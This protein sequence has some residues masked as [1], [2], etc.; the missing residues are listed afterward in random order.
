MERRSEYRFPFSRYPAVRIALLLIAG[1]LLYQ[2]LELSVYTNIILF[3][4]LTGIYLLTEWW[5]NRHISIVWPNIASLLF[6]LI[7]VGFGMF[8]TSIQA[9]SDDSETIQLLQISD[10][11]EVQVSGNVQSMS[12]TSAGKIRWDL[13]VEETKVGDVKTDQAYKSRIL[14][15]ELNQQP[16]LGDE[17]EITGILIPISEKRNPEDFDYKGYLKTQGIS[18]QIK[19]NTLLKVTSNTEVLEWIWW[20]EKALDLVDKNFNETTAPIAKALLV[21]YKQDLSSESKT[22]FA[23]AGLSH[24]MAVSGLHVG[25]IVA[26]FWIII[27][28]FWTKKYGSQIG[29]ALLI[30]LLIYYAG[31]T[32]FSPS[33]MRASVMAVFLSYG[34]LFHRINDSINLTA[35]AAIV[36]LIVD[37]AQ[38]FEIGFQLS[39]A[40]VLIILLMLPVIQNKL[41]YWVRVRWYGKPL[42]VVIVSLV[43]QF[44]L[45]P[46]QVFY[47]GEIS[48][49]SP[50]ANALFVPLLGVVV[51]LSLIALLATSLTSTVGFI[52]NY[53]SLKFLSWMNDFVTS[54]S[55]WDWAWMNASLDSGFIFVF[56]LFLIFAISAWHIPAMR[57]KLSIGIMA[58][59]CVLLSLNVIEKVQPGKLTVTYFDVGQGDAA[60]MK[61]PQGKHILIDVGV[62]SPGY[63][64]GNSVILPHLKSKG[65]N[66]LDA[67][68]LSH[69]HADHIG[70]IIDL[71][72]GVE[73][74][75]I[76][77]SGYNYDSNLYKN[78]LRKA[79]EKAIPVQ[80]LT[81]GDSLL[82][83]PTMLMV[84][85][86]PDGKIHNSDPNEHSVVLHAIY[87]ESEFLFTGDAGEH[88]EQRIL[89]QYGN[90]LDTDVLKVGHHGSRTSSS[91]SF[92]QEVT[93]E[94]AIISLAESNRFRHPHREALNRLGQTEADLL[95]TSREKA[96]VLE[97]DG[98]KINRVH[99]Y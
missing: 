78:Y 4:S 86:G 95:F 46:L 31:I 45:Y 23:R 77:N 69:P 70:G 18:V 85:L 51:P 20:R 71:M 38:L 35:A 28:Y 99:W 96:I 22:A 97:S 41:P 72:E 26:P 12:R 30:I 6:M 67:V 15:D 33:V 66:K 49:V 80:P 44:G 24:I 43:V 64:S 56:W 21:G 50:L 79:S 62:W 89:Q 39:F 81:A 5:N 9:E 42:M 10:W 25:F 59:L 90:L 94:L 84:V 87:G 83:D 11:E 82:I 8:R 73:V 16:T 17:V 60:L 47:F 29:L 55:G 32:G 93:P 3:G 40:A 14:A 74:E 92:L 13:K 57:W 7:I 36:L 65:I 98:I 88:Q 52:V 19:A 75:V 58:S 68:I 91:L 37:P 63:N 48:L 2:Y 54:A 53:P 1:I 61:T 76:Y 34:K 27:P